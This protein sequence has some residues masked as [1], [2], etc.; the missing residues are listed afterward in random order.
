[1]PVANTDAM[2]IHLEHI[3]TIP[4]GRHAVLVLDQAAWH[5]TKRL[6]KFTNL[7]LLSLPPASPE[8]NPTE[9]VWQVLRDMY[10]ANRCYEDYDDIV[11]SCCDAWNGWTWTDV[12]ENVKKLC[13][14]SW[15]NL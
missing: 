9:Q 6:R 10:L 7:T 2:L 4:E 5:T 15:V 13:S 1:M 8:L 3:S 14:R 11:R 12:P